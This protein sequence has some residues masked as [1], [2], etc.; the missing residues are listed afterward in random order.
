[1]ERSSI[2]LKEGKVY[3]VQW[4]RKYDTIRQQSSLNYQPQA[5]GT[6]QPL[7]QKPQD[8]E[9]VIHEHCK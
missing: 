9:A 1:M 6:I 4:Y 8:S 5:P 2:P 3:I 7:I